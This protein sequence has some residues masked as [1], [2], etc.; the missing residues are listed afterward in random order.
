M[1]EG[2]IDPV[3]SY[4]PGSRQGLPIRLRNTTLAGLVLALTVPAADDA[5]AHPDPTAFAP[6]ALVEPAEVVDCTLENGTRT[7]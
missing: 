7:R 2:P 4:T 1:P 3:P 6:T 5:S